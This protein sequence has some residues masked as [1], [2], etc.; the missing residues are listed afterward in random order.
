M[1]A[2]EIETYY[3]KSK[4]HWRKWLLKNHSKK[5]AVWLVF[6]KKSANKPTLSWSESVDEALCFG[7]I[8]SVKKKLDEERSIQFFSKRKP[9]STW[10]KINKDKVE[11]LIASGEM[12]Q[13]G[14][15]S[16]ELAKKNGSWNI[17]DSVEELIIPDDLK[18]ALKARSGAMDF[19][20]GLSKSTKKPMLQWL[21]MAK[22][23]ETREKRITEIAE[24]AQQKKKPKQFP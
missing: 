5:E 10:S 18:S 20:M 13:A 9:K 16:V 6:Y 3:P 14:L 19:F 22:R 21:V 1:A 8:D 17:L 24:L 15:D 7:W 11:K 12:T 23:A 2:G 4:L